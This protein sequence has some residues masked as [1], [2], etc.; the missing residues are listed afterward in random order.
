MFNFKNK[1][2]NNNLL[3]N[4]LYIILKIKK[5]Q[6]IYIYKILQFYFKIKMNFAINS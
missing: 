4:L 1:F 5:N 6:Y 2:Y 3:V